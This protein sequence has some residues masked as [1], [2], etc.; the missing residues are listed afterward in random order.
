MSAGVTARRSQ[1]AA[2]QLEGAP[3]HFPIQSL[4]VAKAPF[5]DTYLVHVA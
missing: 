3:G 4:E 2:Y 1:H 5:L